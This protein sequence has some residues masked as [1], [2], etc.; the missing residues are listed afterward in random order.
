MISH[1]R[2]TG[3]E[4][5]LAAC[6]ALGACGEVALPS[7]PDGTSPD[8]V[9]SPVPGSEPVAPA[10]QPPP[11]LVPPA[12]AGGG[13]HDGCPHSAADAAAAGDAA[14]P[15]PDESDA[16]APPPIEVEATVPPPGSVYADVLAPGW[17]LNGWGWGTSATETRAPA[18]GQRAI[19]VGMDRAWSGF[20]LA[21]TQNGAADSFA[22]GT[23]EALEF[24]VYTGA[25]P[26]AASALE[27]RLNNGN[28]NVRA[29]DWVQ[30]TWTAE[31]WV[32]VRIPFTALNPSRAT[33]HRIEW[34]NASEQAY[35]FSLDDV[36][37]VPAA[38]VPVV[39]LPA[40]V[41]IGRTV[42]TGQNADRL[43]W[44]DAKGL[45]RSADFV[46]DSYRGGYIRAMRYETAPGVVREAHGGVDPSTGYQGFGYL[47]S[48]YDTGYNG[49]S[50]SADSRDGDYSAQLKNNGSSGL[51]WQGKHHAIRSYSV[52]LHPQFYKASGRGTVKATVHWLI[53]SGRSSLVFSVTF[54]SSANPM[55]SILADSR[56]PYG[57]L[58]WDG[59]G[60][61]AP[62]SG[63]AWG[64]KRRFV[65][66]GSGNLSTRSDW[67]YTEA[68]VVPYNS[69]WAASTD[70]EMGLVD[71]RG[72]ASSISGGDLGVW[73]DAQGRVH[74]SERMNARCWNRTSA[75]ATSCADPSD[76]AGAKMPVSWAWPFQSV[77]YGLNNGTTSKKIAWGTNYGAIGHHS[78]VSFGERAYSGYPFASYTTQV[79]LGLH[80]EQSVLGT[81]STT[82][83]AL[84]T[85]V[86]AQVGAVRSSGIPGVGRSDQ[87]AFEVAGFDP[88]YGGFALLADA[89][90]RSDFTL[91]IGAGTLEHPLVMVDGAAG[92]VQSVSLDGV[93]LQDGVDYYASLQGTRAWLTL[94]RDLTGSHVVSVRTQ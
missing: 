32:H 79:V 91:A 25:T 54:D 18:H 20:V 84:A 68:N 44:I 89:T 83:A 93:P 37:L 22:T 10:Q 58:A 94:V 38:V 87:A 90:G 6:V 78:V 74:G 4:W 43:S 64:D 73:F 23:H 9:A 71:T 28:P 40:S 26:S 2:A 81:V 30:G 86:T 67:T 15:P 52:D 8:E 16:A 7:E 11:A 48:H 42:S 12:D 61:T 1:R 47:V 80:S 85:Q 77:N 33:Y 35:T 27:V 72:F 53:A 14:A 24:D 59:S 49:G 63:V 82:E 76:G 50:D 34:F 41:A 13:G 75:T 69:A 70:A 57:A 5:I 17:N 51:L 39:L 88:V 21:R 65:S 3:T 56:A 45:P 66:S 36:V 92:P 62:V 31:T 46:D 60:G 29:R 19:R 55:D